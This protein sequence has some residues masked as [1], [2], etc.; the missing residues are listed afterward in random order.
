MKRLGQPHSSFKRFFQVAPRSAFLV[1]LSVIAFGFS[2]IMAQDQ[3]EARPR[4]TIGASLGGAGPTLNLFATPPQFPLGLG[5]SLRFEWLNALA[6]GMSLRADLGTQ[7]L[8]VGPLWRLDLSDVINLTISTGI[9]WFD[10]AALGLYGRFGLE[11]RWTPALAAALE[12]GARSKIITAAGA[13]NLFNVSWLL[14][15]VYFF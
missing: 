11:Y 14:G 12:F 9:G 1:L 10:Y 8:E 13:T 3:L 7:A 2:P 15:I 5:A 4:F 6:Q